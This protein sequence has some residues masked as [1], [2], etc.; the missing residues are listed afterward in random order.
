VGVA[1]GAGAL[2][3]ALACLAA[4]ALAG[5]EPA[6]GSPRLIALLERAPLALVGSIRQPH[7]LDA[8]GRAA[9]LE[10]EQ[11]LV[12]RVPLGTR[13]LIVWEE[14]ALGRPERFQEGERVLV[15][16]EPL[17]PLSIW[18]RRLPV[19]AERQRAW[20]VAE[21]G[22]AFLRRPSPGGVGILAHYLALAGP[23]RAGPSGAARLA[24]LARGAAP[25]LA[26][27]AVERLDDFEDL[28]GALAG[29]PAEMLVAAL[30]RD[31]A[32]LRQRLLELLAH[33]RPASLRAALIRALEE[34]GASPPELLAALAEID[35]ELAPARARLL[36]G[37]EDPALRELGAR[38]APLRLTPELERMLRADP[39]PVVRAAAVTRLVE[40]RGGLAT[41]A[42]LAALDDPDTSVRGA[43]ALALGGLG[44]EVV[45]AL[46]HVVDT[47]SP[48]A[49]QA[50]V[51]AL[52]FTGSRE[53]QAELR[54]IADAHPDRG[55]RALARLAVGR[56]MAREH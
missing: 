28:D 33:Q 30:R 24:E 23:E 35:G 12:G 29:P 15:A 31:D 2:A 37:S 39:E 26:R 49:A 8:H 13:V 27:A 14:L 5:P 11:A 47:G 56:P 42:V 17:P 3:C 36:L 48:H 22:D 45:P 18:S 40:L 21:R 43:A 16:L 44:A 19:P 20:A 9:E 50:A 1:R 38:R 51:G 54:E 7:A 55:V 41:G 52:R 10:V 6:A 25:L 53:A 34:P 4:P 46:R 32:L